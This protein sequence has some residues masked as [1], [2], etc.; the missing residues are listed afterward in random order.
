[1]K[2]ESEKKKKEEKEKKNKEFCENLEEGR[3]KGRNKK[4]Q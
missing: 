4:Q 3:I 1:M 2:E